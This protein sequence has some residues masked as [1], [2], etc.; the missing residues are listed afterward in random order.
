MSRWTPEPKWSQ[1][2][3]PL[4]PCRIIFAV[5]IILAVV[6]F[7]NLTKWKCF[8]VLVKSLDAND[9]GGKGSQSLTHLLVESSY[10]ALPGVTYFLSFW[11]HG[12]GVLLGC[13]LMWWYRFSSFPTCPQNKCPRKWNL[14]DQGKINAA[15]NGQRQRNV[16]ASCCSLILTLSSILFNLLCWEEYNF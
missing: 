16:L 4:S 11:V 8:Q 5:K 12:F 3:P 1:C 15:V 10:P 6:C 9:T 14:I 7:C 2:C 13:Q